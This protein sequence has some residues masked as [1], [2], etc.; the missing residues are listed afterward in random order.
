MADI[1]PL[2]ATIKALDPE[3][4][5]YFYQLEAQSLLDNSALSEETKRWLERAREIDYSARILIKMCLKKAASDITQ[6]KRD[7]LELADSLDVGLIHTRVVRFVSGKDQ[8]SGDELQKNS[9]TE[10]VNTLESQR[11]RLEAIVDLS[12][13]LIQDIETRIKEL[14]D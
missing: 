12:Q 4:R 3:N 8:Q 9:R 10:E 13:M 7:W 11:E 1:E 2:I 14:K 6:D 5:E